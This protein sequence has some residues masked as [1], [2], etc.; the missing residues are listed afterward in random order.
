V[1]AISGDGQKAIA[2]VSY[3]VAAP[4]SAKINSRASGGVYTIGQRVPMSFTCSDGVGGPGIVWCKDSN[5]SSSPGYL[6]TSTRGAHRYTVTAISGDGQKGTVSIYYTV[7]A[8]P[9][10]KTT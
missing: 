5:G 1:T 6:S 8:A 2:T 3:T 4:P 9:S 7:A 10:A